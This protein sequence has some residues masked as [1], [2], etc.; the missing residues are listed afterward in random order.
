MISKN[1]R[2]PIFAQHRDFLEQMEAEMTIGWANVSPLLTEKQLVL[3]KLVEVIH[4]ENL[5]AEY[6]RT[7]S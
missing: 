3:K 1:L 6:E 5:D 7:Q 4:T 2:L